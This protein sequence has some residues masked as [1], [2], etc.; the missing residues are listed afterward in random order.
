MKFS[1]NDEIG[2]PV[3][4][5]FALMLGTGRRYTIASQLGWFASSVAVGYAD[6]GAKGR[7]LGICNKL[8]DIE[9]DKFSEKL[10]TCY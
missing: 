6:P 8:R 4:P 1:P 3:S 9:L 2:E 5:S 7:L 10:S